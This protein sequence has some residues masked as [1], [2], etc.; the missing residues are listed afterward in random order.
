MI[1][2]FGQPSRLDDQGETEFNQPR[3]QTPQTLE[4]LVYTVAS[5]EVRT[6]PV[7]TGSVGY[8]LQSPADLYE[9]ENVSPSSSF[10]RVT[11][12]DHRRNSGMRLQTLLRAKPHRQPNHHRKDVKANQSSCFTATNF[13]V[14]KLVHVV[15]EC[16]FG[17]VLRVDRITRTYHE[18]LPLSDRRHIKM[19]IPVIGRLMTL[20]FF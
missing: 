7:T 18:R 1:S 5:S 2:I 8:F 17:P 4:L 3:P 10:A 19:C 16:H 11:S 14:T 12:N 20:S 6:S 15:Q 13:F 9:V